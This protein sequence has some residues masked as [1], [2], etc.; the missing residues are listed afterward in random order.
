MF[1]DDIPVS[2]RFQRG[3]M[4]SALTV[5]DHDSERPRHEKQ[6][7]PVDEYFALVHLQL[8]GGGYS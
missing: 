5:S 1:I 2:R 8:F 3:T 6:I 4:V 7:H